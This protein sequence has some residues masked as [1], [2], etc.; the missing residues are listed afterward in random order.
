MSIPSPGD[1]ML[2]VSI[3]T[4][5]PISTR[6]A[7]TT[8]TSLRSSLGLADSILL[9]SES[10]VGSLISMMIPSTP[11]SIVVRYSLASSLF[12]ADTY[13]SVPLPSNAAIRFS[14]GIMVQSVVSTMT[15]FFFPA[16]DMT[17]SMDPGPSMLTDMYE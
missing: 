2:Q 9:N 3:H 7:D 17:S 5:S 12:F 14:N 8:V 1:I 13:N 6:L 16:R 10:S 11:F 4:L 15:A